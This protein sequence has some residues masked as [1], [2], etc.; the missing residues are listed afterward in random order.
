MEAGLLFQAVNL[1][2]RVPQAQA[3]AGTGAILHQEHEDSLVERGIGSEQS[4]AWGRGPT[5]P[6]T[7]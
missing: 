4:E 1:V 2:A 5:Q 6:E 3:S 7:Q